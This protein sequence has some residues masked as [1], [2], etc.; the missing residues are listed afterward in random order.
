M[1][2][3]KLESIIWGVSSFLAP[4]IIFF[5]IIRRINHGEENIDSSLTFVL[6]VVLLILVN[7]FLD[8]FLFKGDS[9]SNN[10]DKFLN[11]LLA[12]ISQVV[13][14]L[15]ALLILSSSTGSMGW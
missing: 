7:I 15:I 13:S 6:Y 8:L 14:I 11:I 9:I 4:S 1:K 12:L 10:K 5:S 2:I 3:S